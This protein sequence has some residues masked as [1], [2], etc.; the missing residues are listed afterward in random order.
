[1]FRGRLRGDDGNPGV[2]RYI[3]F[4]G[5][6]ENIPARRIEL[7]FYFPVT[8]RLADEYSRTM[9]SSFNI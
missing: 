5:G 6:D 3:A 8:I 1:M 2:T 7:V 9:E 4:L